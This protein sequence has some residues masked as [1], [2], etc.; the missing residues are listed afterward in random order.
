MTNLKSIRFILYISFLFLCFSCQSSHYMLMTG[1]RTGVDFSSGRW[2][3]NELDCPKNSKQKLTDETLKFFR[4]KLGDRVF[5]IQDV[6]GLL[7]P[8]KIN[9]NPNSIKL[10]ELKEGTGFDFFI[11]I[12]THKSKSDLGSIELYEDDYSSGKNE[13]SVILE[14]YDLNLQQIIYSQNVVGIT[15]K[16]NKQSMWETEKSDKLL[17]NVT[18]YK[19]SNA[20]MIG[21]LKRIL[22]DLE[23]RSVN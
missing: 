7:V 19:N 20:L 21:A 4:K 15:N 12:S 8:R 2:L 6:N 18:L 14:I 22:K 16:A 10:K 23:K 13:A 3:L 1:Q 17:D 5:Y 11:N 9:L